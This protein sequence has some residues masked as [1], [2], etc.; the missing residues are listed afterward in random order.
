MF[1][2]LAFIVIRRFA[3]PLAFK[4]TVS[5]RN[6]NR[7]LPYQCVRSVHHQRLNKIKRRTRKPHR[8]GFSFL[9]RLVSVFLYVAFACALLL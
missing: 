2:R 5:I 6:I 9:L 1:P 3:V 7:K 4:E 8:Y